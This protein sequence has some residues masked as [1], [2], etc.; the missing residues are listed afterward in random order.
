MD[1]IVKTLSGNEYAEDREGGKSG[2]RHDCDHQ[3]GAPVLADDA[4]VDHHAD[5]YEEYRTE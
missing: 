3:D 1:G 4:R 5:G 2:H